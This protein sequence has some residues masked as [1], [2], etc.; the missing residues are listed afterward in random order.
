MTHHF[1]TAALITTAQACK[2]RF[3][4][5]DRLLEAAEAKFRV[6][7]M[8]SLTERS[9][10]EINSI[11]KLIDALSPL[12]HEVGK[13]KVHLQWAR[14][15]LLKGKC[16]ACYAR[17]DEAREKFEKAINYGIVAKDTDIQKRANQWLL[18]ISDS[19]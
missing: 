19:S 16:L 3:I 1:D 12:L 18:F 5:I 9:V 14:Y 11:A 7:L 15:Y 4:S 17:Y 10:D 13:G 8:K 6:F 2:D